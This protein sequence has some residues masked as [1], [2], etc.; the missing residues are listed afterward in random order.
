MAD[1]AKEGRVTRNKR[2]VYRSSWF[3]ALITV[4][5]LMGLVAS[6]A[7]DRAE[8]SYP[9]AVVGGE[10][11]DEVRMPTR[12]FALGGELPLVPM[13]L[14]RLPVQERIAQA[15]KLLAKMGF[16]GVPAFENEKADQ[17]ATLECFEKEIAPG[18]LLRAKLKIVT[19]ERAV[20]F[21]VG[22]FYNWFSL[23]GR[24]SLQREE[25]TA[26]QVMALYAR[27]Y[28]A[29]LHGGTQEQPKADPKGG[30]NYCSHGWKGDWG[31]LDYWIPCP[32]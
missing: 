3:H 29:L 26:D 30:V 20:S 15:R 5:F 14:V 28:H 4:V 8:G 24:M 31:E 21:T 13:A 18:R 9:V 16:R 12:F 11:R 1:D 2:A 7:V 23:T 19:S 17:G 32:K 22:F 27:A 10:G 25:S 6:L